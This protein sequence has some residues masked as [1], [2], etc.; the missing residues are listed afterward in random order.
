MDATIY[1]INKLLLLVLM[2]KNIQN[3]FFFT[4]ASIF[5]GSLGFAQIGVPQMPVLNQDPMLPE[6]PPAVTE[7]LDQSKML[8]ETLSFKD[9]ILAMA[10]KTEKPELL[11]Q[12]QEIAEALD[13]IIANL[14][15]PEV[16]LSAENQRSVV[17]A[18]QF[19]QALQ[20]LSPEE[21][22]EL[23]NI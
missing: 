4:L 1:V 11:A 3:L 12:L 19:E 13:Q 10:G 21:K 5:L 15:A 14:Q 8:E 20:T 18:Q 23:L 17:V 9:K 16:D 7:N 22:K 2:K 6:N